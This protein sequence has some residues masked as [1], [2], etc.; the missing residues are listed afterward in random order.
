M[1]EAVSRVVEHVRNR[2]L[3]R[4]DWRFLLPEP[5]VDRVL[6]LADDELRDACAHMARQVDTAPN[7]ASVDYDVVVVVDP[8]DRTLADA[9]QR[10]RPGGHLYVEWSGATRRDVE[11]RLGQ[12]AFHEIRCL[13]PWPLPPQAEVWVPCD[14]PAMFDVYERADRHLYVNRRH[15]LGAF[16]RRRIF[17]W[18]MALGRRMAICAIARKPVPNEAPADAHTEPAIVAVARAERGVAPPARLTVGLL[19][20][21][22]RSISK[23]V[24]LAYASPAR[25]P[26]AAIK[27][28]RVPESVPG[29]TREADALAACHAR[30]PARGVPRLLGRAGTGTRL[31]L[32]ETAERGTPMFRH[33]TR[34]TVEPLARLGAAWLAELNAHNRALPNDAPTVREIAG[35]DI[36]RFA[37]TFG[38]V[39]DAALLRETSRLCDELGELPCVIEHRDFG[40]WNILVDATGGVTV[41]DWES[42]R[43]RG[44]PLLDLLYFVTYMAF[45]VDGAMLSKRFVESYRRSLDPSTLTGAIRVEL[46]ERHRDAWRISV[47][48]ARALRALC[49]IGHAESEFQALTADAGGPPP[50]DALRTSVFAQLWRE[51]M[52]SIR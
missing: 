44:L 46:M 19:T 32:A 36:A 40:P 47:R 8:H 21:G 11:R 4:V 50:V 42:S 5:S 43:I 24:G 12:A 10:L 28:A 25:D 22:P 49:W 39:V 51:E 13:W 30:D 2:Q 15:R 34:T 9:H 35:R 6:C 23:V 26:I 52:V 37:E 14:V 45:F 1:G 18:R 7:A 48:A 20:G 38:P 31:A 16:G 3:R 29:L 41:L 27:W 17:R 33:I